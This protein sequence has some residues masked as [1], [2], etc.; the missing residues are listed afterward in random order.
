M[1]RSL[2]GVLLGTLALYVWGM[3]YWGI[4]PLPYTAWHRSTN[5]AEAGQALLKHFPE[6][7]TYYLPGMYNDPATLA[8]L[9]ESGPIAFIHVTSR[10]GRPRNE[11]TILVKG[12]LL[13]L[14]VVALPAWLLKLAA[15]AARTYGSRIRVAAVAGLTAAVLVDFGDMVWWYLPWDW[16]L[17]QAVYTFSAWV[18]PAL[19]LAKFIRPEA[20]KAE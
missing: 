17:H 10:E 9:Y 20:L 5:D 8:K 2:L 13:D 19:V 12:F 18:V 11:R 14:V 1:K 6:S 7:G 15:P 16:K 3:L 4:N